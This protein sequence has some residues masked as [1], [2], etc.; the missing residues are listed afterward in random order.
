MER[1]LVFVKP[2]GVHRRLVGRIVQR[3]E[4]KGL[5]LIG[6]KMVQFTEPMARAHYAEHQG[7]DF[8]EPLVRFMTAGPVVLVALEGPEAVAEARRMV[9]ATSGLQADPGT[10]RGDFGL[11]QRYNLIHAADSPQ[12]AKRELEQLFR[13]GELVEW[14]PADHSWIRP[15]PAA[16][17]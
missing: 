17:V 6:L 16:K 14:T 3:F 9:G 12:A 5:K 1:T 11:S 4:E 10:I 15:T 8:F 2:D 13:P 7:K